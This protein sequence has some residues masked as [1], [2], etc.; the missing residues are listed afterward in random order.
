MK[1]VAA[2]ALT[3]VVLLG[4]AALA[5]QFFGKNAGKSNPTSL[6]RSIRKRGAVKTA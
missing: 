1:R 3:V 6:A 5:F 4:V 2:N